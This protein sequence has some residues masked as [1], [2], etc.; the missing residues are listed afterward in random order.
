MTGTIDLMSLDIDGNDYWIWKAL[1]IVKPRVVIAEYNC[2]WGPDKSV[3]IPYEPKFIA[4]RNPNPLIPIHSV[5]YCGASLLAFKKLAEAKG[6]RLVGINKHGYNAFFVLDELCK[7]LPEKPLSECFEIPLVEW[8]M[9][10]RFQNI[11]DMPWE[12]V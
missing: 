7:N 11:K 12:E 5:D 10:S 1:N 6:Y 4:P 8:S 9:E 3:T 2:L